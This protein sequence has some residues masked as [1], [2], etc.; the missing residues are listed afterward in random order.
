MLPIAPGQTLAGKYRIESV[1]GRGGMGVVLAAT[2]VQLEQR[3]A[4][5]FLV[6][7]GSEPRMRERFAREARAAS[8]IRSEHVAHVLDVGTLDSGIPYMVMEYLAGMDLAR[9]IKSR[10]ALPI[11][12]A[13]GYVLQ[14][15]EALAEAHRAGIVHRDLKP[16][17]VFLARRVDGSI[18][19]KLLDFGVSKIAPRGGENG[20]TGGATILGS[21]SYMPP[22]QIRS[23]SNVDARGDLWSLGVMLFE[24][25]T[26][27]PPFRGETLPELCVA[28]LEHPAPDLA[29][30]APVAPEGVREVIRRCLEKEPSAR[31]ATVAELAAALEPF[32]PPEGRISVERVT[33]MLRAPMANDPAAPAPGSEPEIL[34]LQDATTMRSGADDAAAEGNLDAPPSSAGPGGHT[35]HSVVS[36]N[37]HAKR[38]DAWLPVPAAFAATLL[39][40]GVI[41]VGVVS[42]K[43]RPAPA[44]SATTSSE[45]PAEASS[46]FPEAAATSFE[47][48][49]AH[50][51]A[52]A[53]P[54]AA[55]SI[56]AGV[57]ASSPPVAR[58]SSG[59]SGAP[60]AKPKA[61]AK[62]TPLAPE[63][64]SGTPLSGTPLSGTEGFG[65]RK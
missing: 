51:V 19:V 17:N 11:E 65:D 45:T 23:A 26:G 33:R 5:K 58:R 20:I 39:L 59:A 3:V 21:P 18:T 14:A 27:R 43:D 47:L 15:C 53:E 61:P 6:D 22:E 32:G 9:A 44:A 35:A 62:P 12:E 41:A 64:P 24:L 31:F 34:R 30:V 48:V 49:A 40:A 7:D 37:A 10:G 50:D 54:R 2:H 4:I 42:K 28:I 63:A 55:A 8:K 52:T 1:L 36:S 13:I 56:D 25:I 16:A 38:R 60:S 46:P 57:V 29:D